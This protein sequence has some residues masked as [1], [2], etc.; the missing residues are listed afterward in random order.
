MQE[1]DEFYCAGP[2]PNYWK[3]KIIKVRP[4]ISE[5]S[6]TVHKNTDK[7]DPM[8]PKL[9]VAQLWCFPPAR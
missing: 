7:I 2:F 4:W 1:G 9:A 8:P 3:L 5:A 6:V